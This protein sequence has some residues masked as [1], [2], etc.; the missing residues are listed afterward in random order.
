MV[1]DIPFAFLKDVILLAQNFTC[2]VSTKSSCLFTATQVR[3]V[4]RVKTFG[5]S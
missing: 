5:G 1:M 2:C 3:G 4:N